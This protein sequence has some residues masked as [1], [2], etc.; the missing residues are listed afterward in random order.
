M[1]LIISLE[2]SKV[3]SFVDFLFGDFII[4]SR[5]FIVVSSFAFEATS[6][7]R[8]GIGDKSIVLNSG[9]LI[10]PSPFSSASLIIF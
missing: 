2:K 6:K 4:V 1:D 10:S 3:I 7:G 5:Y 9:K 8:R